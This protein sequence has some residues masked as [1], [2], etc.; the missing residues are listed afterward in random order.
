MHPYKDFF[1]HFAR[2]VIIGLILTLIIL[3]IGMTGYHYF[4]KVSWLDAYVNAAMIISGLG[5]LANPKTLLGKLF[6]GTYSILGG[7]S[8][9]LIM[10]IVFA[11]IFHWLFR[12]I[13]VEDR[14]HFK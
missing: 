4:E 6:I 9:L 5:T 1:L 3:L 8:F 11:P 7:G 14:E 12:Q 2:N 10:A 13:H